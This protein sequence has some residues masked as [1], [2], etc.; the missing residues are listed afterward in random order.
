M[1]YSGTGINDTEYQALKV[2]SVG[3]AE[4]YV[5]EVRLNFQWLDFNGGFEKYKYYDAV[6]AYGFGSKSLSLKETEE[7]IE[8][9]QDGIAFA[10][11]INRWLNNNPEYKA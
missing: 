6:V 7:F 11:S 4:E 1:E 3:K 2:I 9:L 8:V 10:R 5:V